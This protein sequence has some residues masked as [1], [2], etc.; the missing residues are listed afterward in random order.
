LKAITSSEIEISAGRIETDC[1]QGFTVGETYLVYA[2]GDSLEALSSGACTRTNN[3]KYSSDDLYYLHALLKGIPESRV[4]GG[5][6]RI[7]NDLTKT[8]SARTSSGKGEPVKIRVG[9]VNEP[10]RVVIPFPK[11]EQ[12]DR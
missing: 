8:T 4:Y 5:V 2:Y 10:L 3:L 6:T 11:P 7:E 12:P 1:F 9:K